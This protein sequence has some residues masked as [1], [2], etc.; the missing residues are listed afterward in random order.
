MYR[1]L[2]FNPMKTYALTD[3][4]L[5]RE[6][7]QDCYL[8][9]KVGDGMLLAV[10]DGLG[11]H[12]G[13]EVASGAVK[14]LMASF[15]PASASPEKELRQEIVKLSDEL[16]ARAEGNERLFGMGSTVTAVFI[17]GT[18]V[19]WVHVGDSRLYH[20]Q[21]SR[22]AQITTDQNW[23]QSMV[24][25]GDMTPEEARRSP[26]RNMLDEC[27]GCPDC[28]PLT[29]VFTVG[30]NDCLFLSTDGIHDYLHPD[31]F[32]ALLRQE[33]SLETRLDE[34]MQAALDAGGADNQTIIG[35][36]I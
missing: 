20:L 15:E 7:N 29:G 35:V 19:H 3:I 26:L 2:F 28:Q 12:P 31:T 30:K 21:G 32:A 4:G 22:M 11:G 14:D 24:E 17:T 5:V 23:A 16:L 6:Y 1:P 33:V 27:V 8:I 10:A 18:R 36:E 25:Y 13:G 34:V 9:R